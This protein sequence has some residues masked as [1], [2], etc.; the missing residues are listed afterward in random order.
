MLS[1]CCRDGGGP[2]HIHGLSSILQLLL[3]GEVQYLPGCLSWKMAEISVKDCTNRR[4]HVGA[5]PKNENS[6]NN[7]A[8]GR[9]KQSVGH[10]SFHTRQVSRALHESCYLN[11]FTMLRPEWHYFPQFRNEAYHLKQISLG[12][13]SHEMIEL[14]LSNGSF[15]LSHG[16]VLPCLYP[17]IAGT[18]SSRWISKRGKMGGSGE[19]EPGVSSGRR[20]S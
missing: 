11:L 5:A 15:F 9:G 6:N 1:W 7:D 3:K 20:P 10:W 4:T 18:M 2:S 13:K 17:S 12:W 16:A 8:G 14:E 19:S